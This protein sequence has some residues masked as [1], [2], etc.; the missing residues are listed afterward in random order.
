MVSP[1]GGRVAQSRPCG[2][3][4]GAVM[5]G[6]HTTALTQPFCSFEPSNGKDER[7]TTLEFANGAHLRTSEP[8]GDT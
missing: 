8:F 5:R 4:L 1:I 2:F 7:A 3:S 6:E